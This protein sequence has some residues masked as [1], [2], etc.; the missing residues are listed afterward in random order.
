MIKE[1]NVKRKVLLK[2]YSNNVQAGIR[3]YC[4]KCETEIDDVP[5]GVSVE[6]LES[7]QRYGVMCI[8]C[9]EKIYPSLYYCVRHAEKWIFSGQEEENIF[10]G[11]TT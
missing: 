2:I 8:P 4:V 3:D 10:R 5:F 7:G 11:D 6:D 1:M 9:L